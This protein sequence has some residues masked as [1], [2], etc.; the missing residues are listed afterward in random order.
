MSV[1][2]I[3]WKVV[4]AAIAS[5]AILFAMPTAMAGCPGC[6][7][8]H[9]G[10]ASYCSSS[11]KI[12][13]LD[14]TV[15]PSCYCSSCGVSSNPSPPGPPT[16]VYAVPGNGRATIGFTPPTTGTQFLPNAFGSPATIT[17][18]RAT[19]GQYFATGTGSP[20]TVTGLTNGVTYSCTVL[21]MSTAGNGQSSTPVEVT[22]TDGVVPEDQFPPIDFP[23]GWT[24]PDGSE[25]PWEIDTAFAYEGRYS[26]RS[27]DISN[28]GNSD[29]SFTATFEAGNVSF[30]RK[31]SS[32]SNYDHLEF[33]I[34][35][36][37][38]S[39]WSGEVSWSVVSF[40]IAEGTHTLLWRYKKDAIVSSGS[41][42]SWI[43]RVMMPLK[44]QPGAG[45]LGTPVDGETVSG[46]GVISGY[47]C[48]STN[49]EVFVDGV[50]LG[51]AGAGTTLLGTQDVCGR[52]DT[53]Y[54]LLYAF[55]NLT[56]GQ[57][58]ISVTADGVLFDSHT[59]TTFQSGGQPWLSD[60]SRTVTVPDFPQAGKSTTLKWTQSY[61]NFLITAIANADQGL[62]LPPGPQATSGTAA[63]A[64]VGVLGT[65][66][67]GD[68]VSG[69]GVI[70][71]YHC[72]S[73][74]IEVLVDGVS[75]GKAGAGTTLLGTQGVCGRTDT[76]YSLLYAFNNLTNGQHTIAV[77]ADGVPFDTH[78][79]TTFRSG[80]Q[81]WLT[82]VSKSVTVPNFP[83]PGKAAALKWIESYQNFLV[84]G[85]SNQAP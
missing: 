16:D 53:G 64:S 28:N 25:A 31:V 35:G 50:S 17:G 39:R 80:G 26:L 43:D 55:N 22:P 20:I 32:E 44:A 84:T 15:S 58:V 4:Y 70:S 83:Q 65:P 36:F 67:D 74:N 7:S 37:L 19:C 2:G 57:H 40:P 29:I 71:G 8:G 23:V 1:S 52:T 41:D 62:E 33:Y 24:Q 46:V 49:I 21:A 12:Y 81:P 73:K 30:A 60:V 72:T 38:K 56:N 48:T 27:G 34:D 78:V 45:V 75:L 14:G 9:G 79:V 63:V 59:V 13:C 47:H 85:I 18:Y 6:C 76:G 5:V 82:G 68:T 3:G 66:V 69:V 61:Q 77:T 11:G 42:A 10:I 51:T 54:S